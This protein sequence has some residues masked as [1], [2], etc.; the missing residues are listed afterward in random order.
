ML[1]RKFENSEF[2]S[3][4]NSGK[5]NWSLTQLF[6]KCFRD[7]IMDPSHLSNWT[8]THVDWSDGGW[9]PRA[10][11]PEDVTVEVLEKIQVTS[12]LPKYCPIAKVNQYR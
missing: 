8:V 2:L 6:C 7:Q 10:Y 9:H 3:V 12:R 11:A 5:R 1:I 4:F